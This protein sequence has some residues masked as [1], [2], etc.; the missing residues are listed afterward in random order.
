L[1]TVDRRLLPSLASSCL[2]PAIDLSYALRRLLNQLHYWP[3][4]FYRFAEHY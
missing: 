3:A 2:W 4:G 1:K